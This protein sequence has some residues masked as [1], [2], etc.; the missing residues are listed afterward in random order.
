MFGEDLKVGL[1]SCSLPPEILERLQSEDDL[2]ALCATTEPTSV[3]NNEPPPDTNEASP[4]PPVPATQA[5]SVQDHDN[6]PLLNSK[7]LHKQ[8]QDITNQRKKARGSQL[9]QAEKWSSDPVLT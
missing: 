6:P 1:R 5:P 3:H 9:S 7:L 2:L 4:S 8:L